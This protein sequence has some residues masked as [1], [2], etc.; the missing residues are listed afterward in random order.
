MCFSDETVQK[1][2]CDA[3]GRCECRRPSHDHPF[4]G[5]TNELVWESRGRDSGRGAWEVHH[6]MSVADGG[7]DELSNCEILCRECHKK[8]L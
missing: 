6:M 7:G 1:A 5:C 2:W 4:T 8:T 3:K